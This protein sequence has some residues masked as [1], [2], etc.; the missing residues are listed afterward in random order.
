MVDNPDGD[1]E[2]RDADQG[3]QVSI[4]GRITLVNEAPSDQA[5]TAPGQATQ[6][7][8]NNRWYSRFFLT[9]WILI[10]AYRCDIHNG[11]VTAVATIVIAAFTIVLACVSNRQW[12]AMVE[13]NASIEQNFIASERPYVSMGRRDGT[14]GNFIVPTD[15]GAK[16]GIML[17][18]HNSGHLPAL[19]FNVSIKPLHM[20]RVQNIASGGITLI[21]GK[22]DIGGD[23]DAAAMFEQKVDRQVAISAEKGTSRYRLEGFFEYCDDFGEYTCRDFEITYV[24]APV[25]AFNLLAMNQCSYIYPPPGPGNRVLRPCETPEERDAR[26]KQEDRKLTPP[27]P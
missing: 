3:L 20:V 26:Q 16:A 15:P 12:E 21:A 11:T 22:K 13:S 1:E 4:H 18:F 2:K 8:Q 24:T 5:T 9:R 27:S 17:Y 25:D 19:R 10:G 7:A 6:Q 23:S 14:V